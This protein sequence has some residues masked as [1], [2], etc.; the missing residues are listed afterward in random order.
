MVTAGKAAGRPDL[1]SPE[2]GGVS[3]A[4]KADVVAWLAV[5][6]GEDRHDHAA[7]RETGVWPLAEVDF[8]ADPVGVVLSRAVAF[9]RGLS[10]SD[11]A[12]EADPPGICVVMEAGDQ[13]GQDVVLDGVLVEGK[14]HLCRVRRCR[15]GTRWLRASS[16]RYW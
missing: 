10:R 13:V 3:L 16:A 4:G 1:R 7:A 9:V 14:F 6:L 5:A 2:G 11:R 8:V 15:R 12:V